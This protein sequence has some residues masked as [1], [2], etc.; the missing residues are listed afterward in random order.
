MTK[1]LNSIDSTWGTTGSEYCLQS[2][3]KTSLLLNSE[4]RYL[5]RLTLLINTDGQ[6]QGGRAA[7][8]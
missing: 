5:H 4:R 6:Q 2:Q 7:E 1:L 8:Q 3:L